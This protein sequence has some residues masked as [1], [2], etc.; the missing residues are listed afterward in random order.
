LNR[1]QIAVLP[2]A[3]VYHHPVIEEDHMIE[4]ETNMIPVDIPEEADIRGHAI[5][6]E[7]IEEGLH[8]ISVT[9]ERE[10]PEAHHQENP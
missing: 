7:I 1:L 4:V 10:T 8:G 5:M 3:E 9:T 6:I 2:L